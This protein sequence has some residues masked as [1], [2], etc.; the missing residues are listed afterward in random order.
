MEI[1][2]DDAQFIRGNVP[3][4]KQEIRILT[5]VKAHIHHAD[6]VYDI[7]AGTGSLSIEAANLAPDG[8]VYALERNAE[9]V[10]LIEANKKHF[11]I[12]N[13]EALHAE[14]PAGLDKLP[15]PNVVLIGGS[16][17]H[18][19]A[20]LEAVTEKLVP[21]GR[22]VL[23]CITLQTV[24]TAISFMRRHEDIYTYDAIQVQV[25][26]L[27]RVGPYDMAK[28]MNPIYI[29]TCKKGGTN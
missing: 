2:I 29:I 27:Q 15:P 8:R 25:S 14:A 13:V 23:N 3:M 26:R 5:I 16:G 10:A 28:A 21:G 4:T 18:L 12:P 6:I 1:G 9:A 17:K 20:I 19:N 11:N 7:G 24:M 22:I